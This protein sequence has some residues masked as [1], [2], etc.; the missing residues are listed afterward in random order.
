MRFVSLEI[1]FGA[2][3]LMLGS[4]CID[5]LITGAVSRTAGLHASWKSEPM[6]YWGFVVTWGLL[7]LMAAWV[8][9]Q[10]HFTT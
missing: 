4:I 7:G 2:L 8:A 10:A 5:G 1:V 6:V 9:V 3:A